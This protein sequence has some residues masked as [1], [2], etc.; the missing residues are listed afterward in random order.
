MP[1]ISAATIRRLG[2][3][4]PAYERMAGPDTTRRAYHPSITARSSLLVFVLCGPLPPIAKVRRLLLES[5]R[6]AAPMRF[7]DLALR[8]SRFPSV[9]FPLSPALRFTAAPPNKELDQFL[10]EF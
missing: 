7:A 9:Q 8:A 10:I 6:G 3:G 1:R 5:V 4:D 2:L